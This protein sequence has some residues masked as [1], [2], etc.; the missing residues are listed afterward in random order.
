MREFAVNY[1]ETWYDWNTPSHLQ[2]QKWTWRICSNEWDIFFGG[3]NFRFAWITLNSLVVITQVS[4]TYKLKSGHT[5]PSAAS[6]VLAQHDG[7]SSFCMKGINTHLQRNL[8]P[9]CMLNVQKNHFDVLSAA[10][11][12]TFFSKAIKCQ[13]VAIA[14]DS[15][16]DKYNYIWRKYQ[17]DLYFTTWGGIFC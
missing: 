7:S 11:E 12:L 13:N 2:Q 5:A 10:N 17:I 4:L 15:T 14:H 16:F 8:H 6:E 3:F 9:Y 1:P